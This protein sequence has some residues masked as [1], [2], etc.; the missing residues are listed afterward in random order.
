MTRRGLNYVHRFIDD[1]KQGYFFEVSA[2]NQMPWEQIELSLNEAVLDCADDIAT[3][4]SNRY[5]IDL[6]RFVDEQPEFGDLV[7]YVL[8]NWP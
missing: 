5:C 3:S 7:D 6:P 8:V 2:S 1:F 4:G